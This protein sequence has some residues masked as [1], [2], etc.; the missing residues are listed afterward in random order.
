MP[1]LTVCQQA[2][3][4]VASQAISQPI[5]GDFNISNFFT[6]TANGLFRLTL[7]L[8]VDG[9]NFISTASVEVDYSEP[10]GG[11][12]D[13]V[14]IID[15]LS[16]GSQNALISNSIISAVSGSAIAV[17][18]NNLSSFTHSYHGWVVLEQLA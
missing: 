10:N 14:S 7:Y 13:S 3:V 1:N 11:G 4:I 12:S 8:H 2:P 15:T 6:P 17:Y 18:S 5:G 16:S 9:A